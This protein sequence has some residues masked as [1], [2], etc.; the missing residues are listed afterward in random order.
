MLTAPSHPRH[1]ELGCTV[2]QLALAWV[3]RNP[4]TS[5]VI[6]GATKPEQ[7]LENLKALEV[8]PKLTPD[9]LEKIE[10][11]LGTKPKP[12]VRVLRDAMCEFVLTACGAEPVRTLPARRTPAQDLSARNT[13]RR[14]IIACI[15]SGLMPMHE[16]TQILAVSGPGIEGTLET[17]EC[18]ANLVMT[19][20]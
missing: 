19:G 13:R 1:T 17:V 11:I 10:G 16:M 12:L 8:I 20:R 4:N 15:C 2:T 7:L 6:L 5:T 14:C 9:V 18:F 3:A